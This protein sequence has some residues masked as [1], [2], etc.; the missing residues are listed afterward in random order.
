LAGTAKI[1][2]IGSREQVHSQLARTRS[3][4]VELDEGIDVGRDVVR[5]YPEVW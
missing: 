4:Q 2:A 5:E 3:G 1:G